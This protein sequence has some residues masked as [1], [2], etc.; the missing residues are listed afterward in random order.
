[1]IQTYNGM[2]TGQLPTLA[3]QKSRRSNPSGNCVEMAELPGGAGIAVR[4]SR[5]PDGPALIYTI[6]EI[7]AFILGARDGDFDN[8]IG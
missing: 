2:S 7:T 6:D 3:W 5:D 1:M 4:N 8:L